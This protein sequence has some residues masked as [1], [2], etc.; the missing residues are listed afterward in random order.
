MWNNTSRAVQKYRNTNVMTGKL[1]K[2]Y[3]KLITII[4]PC[5]A[6]HLQT[7][8]LL[9][10]IE[11]TTYDKKNI[12][13]IMMTDWDMPEDLINIQ[14]I[15]KNLSYNIL[16]IVRD[17]SLN[18]HQD[19]INLAALMTES[20][21]VWAMGN[22]NIIATQDWDHKLMNVV[23]SNTKTIIDDTKEYYIYVDDDT[24]TSERDKEDGGRGCCFP[25]LSNNFCVKVRGPFPN[26]IEGW[27]ADQEL[28]KYFIDQRQ[29]SPER[30]EII[31]VSDTIKLEHICSH[32]NKAEIDEIGELMKE[33]HHKM[34]KRLEQE[35]AAIPEWCGKDH[36]Q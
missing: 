33:R 19:Y 18:L 3:K 5:R 4:V 27:G 21:Y 7:I 2:N 23:D 31:D 26:W 35:N 17:Q 14:K 22:D 24:H 9:E 20:Y 1:Y 25:I 11:R 30:F 10:S 12:D 13:V 6:R 36:Q 29:E 16:T 8:E 15:K 34:V 28:Y 32:N